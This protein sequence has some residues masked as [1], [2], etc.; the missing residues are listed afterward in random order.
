MATPVRYAAFPLSKLILAS[1]NVIVF[2]G[3]AGAPYTV[4]QEI[5]LAGGVT[6]EN[7]LEGRRWAE[8][9]DRLVPPPAAPP[10]GGG[11]PPLPGATGPGGAPLGGL[12]GTPP[13]PTIPTPA[14]A[15]VPNPP[16]STD[17]DADGASITVDMRPPAGL[18]TPGPVPADAAKLAAAL[19]TKSAAGAL[20]FGKTASVRGDS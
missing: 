9:H 3:S 13:P 8:A 2:S 14:M 11:A 17:V 6:I 20:V 10:G 19:L 4:L 7:T 16:L 12:P 5:V 1:G 15:T 18:P